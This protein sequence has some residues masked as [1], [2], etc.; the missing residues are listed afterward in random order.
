MEIQN[1]AIICV[2]RFNPWK[3]SCPIGHC[4]NI[5]SSRSS[6]YHGDQRCEKTLVMG[7]GKFE[8]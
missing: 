4:D 5:D 3:S 6:V 7:W 1:V 2:M 8:Q